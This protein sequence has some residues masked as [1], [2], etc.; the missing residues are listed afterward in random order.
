MYYLEIPHNKQLKYVDSEV[1][2]LLFV[3][4]KEI[5]FLLF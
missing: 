3:Y 1:Q 4:V 5:L 2:T